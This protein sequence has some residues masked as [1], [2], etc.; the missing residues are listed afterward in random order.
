[1]PESYKFNKT[2]VPRQ[3]ENLEKLSARIPAAL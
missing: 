1:M 3:E 2:T